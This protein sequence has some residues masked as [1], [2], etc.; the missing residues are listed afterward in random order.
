MRRFEYHK[1]EVFVLVY[2]FILFLYY[3]FIQRRILRF[4]E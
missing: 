1:L 4:T 2:V 3:F